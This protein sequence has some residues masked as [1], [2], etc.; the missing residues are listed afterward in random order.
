MIFFMKFQTYED[1]QNVKAAHLNAS[2][3][4]KRIKSDIKEIEKIRNQVG[5]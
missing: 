4:I 2:Q 1:W 5:N 3:I